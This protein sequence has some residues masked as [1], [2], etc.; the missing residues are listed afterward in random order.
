MI[1]RKPLRGLH[2]DR[3]PAWVEE[4]ISDDDLRAEAGGDPVELWVSFQDWDSFSITALLKHQL[5]S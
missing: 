5:Q 2:Y 1:S 4:D 3:K